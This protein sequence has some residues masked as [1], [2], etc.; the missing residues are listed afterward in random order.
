MTLMV[1]NGLIALKLSVE[2]AHI[3][4]YQQSNKYAI[5]ITQR[6]SVRRNATLS[7]IPQ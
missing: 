2:L 6:L 3:I 4:F 5:E 1:L 7:F